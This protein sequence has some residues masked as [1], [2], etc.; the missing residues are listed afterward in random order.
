M[1]NDAHVPAAY[2]DVYLVYLNVKPTEFTAHLID[3]SVYFFFDLIN[4]FIY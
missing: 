1:P 2:A 4:V 3:Y